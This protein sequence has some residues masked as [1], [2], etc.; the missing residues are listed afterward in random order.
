MKTMDFLNEKFE[1]AEMRK[2][3]R[4][5]L[6][7]CINN[8]HFFQN[9]WILKL[10]EAQEMWKRTLQTTVFRDGHHLNNT[11]I[12]STECPSQSPPTRNPHQIPSAVHEM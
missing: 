1:F 8:F 11:S 12:D 10:R 5:G 6:R 4:S 7:F 2:L 9:N 3:C